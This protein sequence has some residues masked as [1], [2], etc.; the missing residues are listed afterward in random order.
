MTIHRPK[1]LISGDKGFI[2]RNFRRYLQSE[3]WTV[4]GFDIVGQ[5]PIDAI[6]FF[7][8]DD[9][10][11]FDLAIH[12]AAEIPD[13]AARQQNAMPVASNLALDALFFR[14][15]MRTQPTKTVYL[16]SAAAYPIHLNQQGYALAEE[17]I[18]L[19][20]LHEPDGMYGM[21]KLVGE[22]Q[23]RE[24]RRQG[25]HVLVVRPQTGYGE[26]QSADYPFRAIIER[27]KQRQ[28]PLTI[29]GSGF[30]TRDFIHVSDIIG[31]I[32]AMLAADATGPFNIGTGKP[33]T[34][35]A[36]ASIVGEMAGYTPNLLFDTEKPEGSP[37]RHADVEKMHLYWDHR[38]SLEEGIE[39]ALEAK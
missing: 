32:M 25:Q 34:M 6:D 30:Q 23:A 2:G 38:I 36:F 15:C 26:D 29:W 19:D 9:T 17:D 22:V 20:D 24:A 5:P 33:T 3:G 14:W 39:R 11:F 4:Y 8:S 18:D 13:L 21:V 1:A 35:A 28:D 10:P 16:S 27:A 31:A 7:G 37:H 12:C